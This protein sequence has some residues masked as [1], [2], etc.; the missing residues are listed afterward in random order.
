M[1]HD[2]AAPLE[3]DLSLPMG[4]LDPAVWDRILSD[5]LAAPDDD[6]D[7]SIV[8]DY[9]ES[10][11]IELDDADFDGIMLIDAD[12]T[13]DSTDADDD[14]VYGHGAH[15][16]SGDVDDANPGDVDTSDFVQHD[17]TFDTFQDNNSNDHD[18]ITHDDGDGFDADDIDVDF[19]VN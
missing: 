10:D 19:D 5:A 2:D 18:A 14:S 3:P 6:I 9:D 12:G 17:L 4:S 13:D 11:E 15:D 7:A 16:E 8:P 1:S